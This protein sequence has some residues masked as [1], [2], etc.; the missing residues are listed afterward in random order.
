MHR[1]A[2]SLVALQYFT[3]HSQWSQGQAPGV[4][5]A[6][7]FCS[8][9][10]KGFAAALKRDGSE[11]G[12]ES[13]N[14]PLGERGADLRWDGGRRRWGWT[15]MRLQEPAETAASKQGVLSH[16]LTKTWTVTQ[17]KTGTHSP[18]NPAPAWL[19]LALLINHMISR[20]L[21][22]PWHLLF[23]FQVWC[24]LSPL[25]FLLCLP[26]TGIFLRQQLVVS[27]KWSCCWDFSFVTRV[28]LS[29]LSCCLWQD[30]GTFCQLLLGFL[31]NWVPSEKS[32]AV[33]QF[34][35]CVRIYPS[36]YH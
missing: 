16:C 4:S 8:I 9:A 26:C 29:L 35:G 20:H 10:P 22:F 28:S 36:R 21:Q 30:A 1:S 23:H 5:L 33:L 12:S 31:T 34:R 24:L 18:L 19:Y 7:L 32:S 6:L 14:L 15:L 2:L 27:R 13:P 3:S 25:I 17:S 11:S